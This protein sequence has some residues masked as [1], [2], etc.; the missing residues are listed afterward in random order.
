[1]P[2]IEEVIEAVGKASVISKMDLA[3]GHYQVQI[4]TKDIPKI[5]FVCHKQKFEFTRMSF[6]V[7]NVPALFQELMEDM[8][9]FS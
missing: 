5:A 7:R 4:K 1:M 3:K 8:S 2:R 9:S 6:V